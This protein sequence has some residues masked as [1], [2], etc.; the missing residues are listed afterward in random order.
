MNKVFPSAAAA[1]KDVIRDGQTLAVG[2]FGL[3][4]IPES[5]IVAVRDSGAKHLTCI[6]NNAATKAGM[7]I[8]MSTHDRTRM[9]PY[10]DSSIPRAAVNAPH[11]WSTSGDLMIIKTTMG[12]STTMFT[13]SE[14]VISVCMGESSL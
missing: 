14:M 2:G 11:A 12:M 3:C 10:I 4:G 13:A 5:L 8:T 9:V 1:I 6:S 7:G